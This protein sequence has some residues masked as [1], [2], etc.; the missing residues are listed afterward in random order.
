MEEEG[1]LRWGVVLVMTDSTNACSRNM[2][3]VGGFNI[4]LHGKAYSTYSYV[5]ARVKYCYSISK[6]QVNKTL[7]Y[8]TKKKIFVENR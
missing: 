8:Q 7:L 6:L 4:V 3:G 1:E 5:H 2:Y